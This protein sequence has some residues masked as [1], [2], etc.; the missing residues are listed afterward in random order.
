MLERCLSA[1]TSFLPHGR[2]VALA[3]LRALG[4]RLVA[5]S[6]LP[7]LLW[8]SSLSGLASEAPVAPEYQLKAAFLYNFAVFVDWPA[9]NPPPPNG[10]IL[11]GVLGHDPF[12][13]VLVESLAKVP[14]VKGRRVVARRVSTGPEL[15]ACQILFIS[16]SEKARL[17]QILASV[18]GTSLLTVGDCDQFC[19]AG[20]IIRFTRQEGRIGTE[21]NLDAAERAGLQ[22]SSKL[23]RLSS[24]VHDPPRK[25]AP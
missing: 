18:A 1:T 8:A 6:L 7:G 3:W 2:A 12:C 21:I 10:P 23:L 19:Q 5:R 15:R 11:I 25:A 4:P 24:V 9:T 13:S 20:G 14:P 16:S 22:F 17:S